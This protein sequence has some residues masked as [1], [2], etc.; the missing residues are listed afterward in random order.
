VQCIL[1]SQNDIAMRIRQLRAFTG[2][3][4]H[5][6]FRSVVGRV[7]GAA[8]LCTVPDSRADVFVGGP[9]VSINR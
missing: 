5:D 2:L 7:A 3:E 6:S 1:P 4:I 9:R 8:S